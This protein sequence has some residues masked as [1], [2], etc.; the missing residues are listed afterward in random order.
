MK[1]KNETDDGYVN[2][3]AAVVESVVDDYQKALRNQ[4]WAQAKALGRWFTSEYGQMMCLGH[5][6]YIR[7]RARK[8]AYQRKRKWGQR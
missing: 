5:G 2:L 3:A 8:E 6:E 7:E 1:I 4:N